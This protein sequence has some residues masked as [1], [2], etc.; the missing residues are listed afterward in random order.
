MPN[1]NN[2]FST[3][4]DTLRVSYLW[5]VF[6][7]NK[8]DIFLLPCI[9]ALLVF[10]VSLNIE[11]KYSSTS[12]LV[13]KPEENKKTVN[14]EEVYSQDNQVNR[15]NNQIAIL[16]SEEVLEATLKNNN[17]LVKFNEIVSTS[18][19]PFYNR[20]LSKKIL[21]NETNIKNYFRDNFRV[22]NIPR[23]DILEI[24]FVSTHPKIAQ[25][26]LNSI[27]D[28]YQKYEIDSKV[29]ITSYANQKITERL[30]ELNEQMSEAQLKLATYKKTNGLIDTGNV[31]EIKI[32]EIQSLSKRIQDTEKSILENESDISAI[33]LA[34]GNVDQLIAIKDLATRDEVKNIKNLLSTNQSNIA[35]L[36]LVY[37]ENHPKLIQALES[38]KSQKEQLKT[39]LNENTQL[40]TVEL[41]NLKSFLVASKKNL[42]NTTK[43]FR[44]LEDK[45]SG[46]LNFQREVE[47][48]QKLY[49]SFLQR[50]KETNEAQNLQVSNIQL[51]EMP[52]VPIIP[53]SP[54]LLKNSVS[55]YLMSLF[56]VFCIVLYR[57]LR[58]ETIVGI[59][60]LNTLDK[61]TMGYL[62]RVQ[63]IKKGFHLLQNYIEDSESGFSESVRMLRTSIISK[64]KKHTTILVTSG[65]SGDGKTTVAFNLALSLENHHKV[66]IIEADT[67][68]PSVVK[69]FYQFEGKGN[70]GFSDLITN[71]ARF[72]ETIVRVPGTNLDLITA[73]ENRIDITDA[74]TTEQ[75]KSFFTTLASIYDYVIV[76]SPPVL[77]VAD[78][79]VI[80]QAVDYTL[81]VVRSEVTKIMS[82]M[83]SVDRLK[84]VGN[85]IDAF[86]LNDFDRSKDADY[87]ANYYD[88]DNYRYSNRT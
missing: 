75:L 23:S 35:S 46:M 13:I 20:L 51:I 29:K 41:N 79:L 87:Y 65:S 56:A 45:E 68:R 81:F 61:S 8:K 62:P 67:K 82:T 69:A 19:V 73:G 66:L 43:E 6:L 38:E 32:G 7:K 50:V 30:K 64:F 78:T 42:D 37:T 39:I 58:F 55:G 34:N 76:D 86:V 2:T 14:I 27:I 16:K 88:Y 54:N 72:E 22:S 40:K 31:K 10:L 44:E 52:N 53:I 85:N 77:P 9:F 5:Q 26:A 59:A 63:N 25:L 24:S 3:L 4:S 33:E 18:D 70:L 74:V 11:K 28:S 60:E 12:T 80:G 83:N 48:N 57:S 17:L 21:F 84:D 49:E 1:R 71:Q 47:S 15:I 36:R